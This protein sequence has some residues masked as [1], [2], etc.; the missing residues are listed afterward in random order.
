VKSDQEVCL[1]VF[2]VTG[3]DSGV[4]QAYSTP[5]YECKVSIDEAY[6]ALPAGKGFE[7]ARKIKKTVKQELGLPI[8]AGVS[9]N[10]LLAQMDCELGQAKR[11]KDAEAGRRS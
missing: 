9:V 2:Q 4:V 7:T 3:H 8:S 6:L 11:N 10:K 5:L 1:N